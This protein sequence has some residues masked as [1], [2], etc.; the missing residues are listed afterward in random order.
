M[1]G[2]LYIGGAGLARSYL[3]RLE[4][5]E[6]KFIPDPF[7]PDSEMRLY[8]TG[9]LARFLENGTF[10]CLGRI[11]YQVKI[12]GHRIEL[13]EVESVL[14]EHSKVSQAVVVS[15]ED[16]Q[17][18]KWLAAYV[19]ADGKSLPTVHELRDFLREKLPEY[20]LPLHFDF[21]DALPLT[22]NGKID[23]ATTTK[24]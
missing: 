18:E 24:L 8:K 23:R 3:N 4:L 13:G 1:T 16:R 7:N 10:E 17:Q 14:E 9:D 22:P 6:E 20:M 11:D 5:T 2:E 19:V 21:L 12:R 15:W